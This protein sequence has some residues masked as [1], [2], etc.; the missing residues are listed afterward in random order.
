MK[1]YLQIS[2]VAEERLNPDAAEF[3]PSMQID[4]D[5]SSF[6]T[7]LTQYAIKE[8]P[9]ASK[10]MCD[11]KEHSQPF[12]RR[13]MRETCAAEGLAEVPSVDAIPQDM[14]IPEVSDSSLEIEC[15]IILE[16]DSAPILVDIADLSRTEYKIAGM[17]CMGRGRG[18]FAQSANQYAEGKGRGSIVSNGVGERGDDASGST[19]P[20]LCRGPGHVHRC[21]HCYFVDGR[22]GRNRRCLRECAVVGG[23]WGPTICCSSC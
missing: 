23:I 4:V 20:V 12:A 2:D 11:M 22:F 17:L 18:C 10:L 6:K 3:I 7:S 13:E 21:E 19:S 1:Q 14:S 5:W 9:L 15:K 16:Q 8:R